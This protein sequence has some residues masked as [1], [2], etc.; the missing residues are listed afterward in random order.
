[1]RIRIKSQDIV[2][3]SDFK[4]SEIDR[5]FTN[6][7]RKEVAFVKKN[8]T[9]VINDDNEDTEESRQEP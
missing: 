4:Q 3:Q 2:S 6:K 8:H 5:V 7:D 9:I 1:M